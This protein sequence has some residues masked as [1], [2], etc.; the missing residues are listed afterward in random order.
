MAAQ[1]KVR[2]SPLISDDVPGSLAVD[3]PI[4]L[5]VAESPRIEVSVTEILPELLRESDRLIAGQ[6][7]TLNSQDGP[8]LLVTG[9]FAMA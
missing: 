9:C 7:I 2:V 4:A 1:M 3:W 8:D 5:I 6:R